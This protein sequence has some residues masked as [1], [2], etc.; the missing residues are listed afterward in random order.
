MRKEL[1]ATEEDVVRA[2]VR[3]VLWDVRYYERRLKNEHRYLALVRGL[4]ERLSYGE[5]D[6][7]K[8]KETYAN[9]DDKESLQ[10]VDELAHWLLGD[11]LYDVKFTETHLACDHENL[12]LAKA[13]LGRGNYPFNIATLTAELVAEE[14]ERERKA[15]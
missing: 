9:D 12:A 13:L 1:C 6:E 14:Q 8:A 11:A 3:S 2:H 15:A 4:L 7:N 10:S 5:I